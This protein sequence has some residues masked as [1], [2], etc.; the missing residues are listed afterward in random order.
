M[1]NW[2]KIETFE[3]KVMRVNPK[4]IGAIGISV[5][6]K[7][8]GVAGYV[9]VLY[10]GFE[11]K[12]REFATDVGARTWVSKTFDQNPNES[13]S[14]KP[15]DPESN[16]GKSVNTKYFIDY[17][18]EAEF[19]GTKRIVMDVSRYTNDEV[20]EKDV[21][22][23]FAQFGTIKYF[24]PRKELGVYEI[25][26]NDHRDHDDAAF[27]LKNIENKYLSRRQHST[28]SKNEEFTEHLVSLLVNV[29]RYEAN[30]VSEQH[31]RGYF[32]RFGSIQSIDNTAGN[33]YIIKYKDNRDCKDAEKSMDE[34]YD[35]YLPHVFMKS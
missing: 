33:V 13:K 5:I 27:K 32:E 9:P 1:V 20:S 29:S 31:I 21:A 7:R 15:V 10:L 34:F 4:L 14:V 25:E 12:C 19:D 16:E 35:R 11:I 22:D 23:F 6:H 3:G 18:T 17:H 24:S 26:Y 30:T 28:K 2:I 8:A